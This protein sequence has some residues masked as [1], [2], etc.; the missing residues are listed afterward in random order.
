MLNQYYFD[1]MHLSWDQYCR[2]YPSSEE[3]SNLSWELAY[4][5]ALLFQV[6]AL[7]LQFL[8]PGADRDMD[9]D[10]EDQGLAD[11]L[12]KK[13]SD[14]GEAVMDTLGRQHPTIEAVQADMLH[15]AWLKNC[16]RGTE[17]WFCLSNAV[18]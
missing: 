8:P 10:S 6:I 5:A 13:F 3:E 14:A 15:C 18:R 16:G 12:S 9:L 4:F 11:Q 2:D 17:S 1:R 7:S